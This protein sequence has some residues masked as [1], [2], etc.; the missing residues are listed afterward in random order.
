[1]GDGSLSAA[2][3]SI[4]VDQMLKPVSSNITATIWRIRGTL[5]V[6]RLLVAIRQT[7]EETPAL[8]VRFETDNVGTPRA[9]PM[10]PSSFSPQFHDVSGTGV[11][12][13]DQRAREKLLGLCSTPFALDEDRLFRV[14]VVRVADD[15]HVLGLVIHHVLTDAYGVFDVLSQRIADAYHGHHRV[16]P[17]G[18]DASPVAPGLREETYRRSPFFAEDADFWR[19]YLDEAAPAARMPEHGVGTPASPDGWWDTLGSPLG[20]S[21]STVVIPRADIADTV[22]ASGAT[23][24]VGFPD[25]LMASIVGFISRVG[26]AHSFTFS[27]TVNFRQGA[28]RN[29]PGLYSNSVP[30]SVSLSQTRSTA[31]LARS[32]KADRLEVLQHAEYNVAMMKRVVGRTGETRSPFGP[33]VNVMPFLKELDLGTAVGTLAGGLFGVPDEV[34]ISVFTDGSPSSDLFARV[35]APAALYSAAEVRTLGGLLA[36]YLTDALRSPDTAIENVDLMP[37]SEGSLGLPFAGDET[38]IDIDALLADRA[39]ASPE[40]VAVTDRESSLSH[41][42]LIEQARSVRRLLTRAGVTSGDIVALGLPPCLALIPVQVGLAMSGAATAPL[43]PGASLDSLSDADAARAPGWMVSLAGLDEIVVTP[44]ADGVPVWNSSVTSADVPDPA[45]APIIARDANAPGYVASGVSLT[46]AGLQALV[47]QTAEVAGIGPGDTVAVR[48]SGW[49]CLCAVLAGASI[50]I[51]PPPSQRAVLTVAFLGTGELTDWLSE[52]GAPDGMRAIIHG[53]EPLPSPTRRAWASA[54]G[55]RLYASLAPSSQLPPFAITSLD[56]IGAN[57]VL[58]GSVG[59][60]DS[61]L[62]P[63]GHG[64]VGRLHAIVP[65]T[66]ASSRDGVALGIHGA[67]SAFALPLLAGLEHGRLRVWG[68]ARRF[69]A[70]PAGTLFLAPVERALEAIDGVAEAASRVVPVESTPSQPRLT[71]YVV[72]AGGGLLGGAEGSMSFAAGLDM[73]AVRTHAGALVAGL[74]TIGDVIV[75]DAILRTPDG[76]PRLDELPATTQG[77]SGLGASTEQEERVADLFRQ[78]LGRSGVGSGDDFFQLGGDSITA[79][80]LA[81]LARR[82]GLTL[83]VRDVFEYRTVGLLAQ[84]V[85]R[86]EAGPRALGS[87]GAS[88]HLYPLPPVAHV[89]DRGEPFDRFAQWMALTSPSGLDRAQLTT[90]LQRLLDRHDALRSRRIDTGM[91]VSRSGSLLAERLLE[92]VTVDVDPTTLSFSEVGTFA[93]TAISHIDARLAD[94]VR[95]VWIEGSSGSTGLLVIVFHHLVIDGVSWQI[96]LDD[97]AAS[98][99]S[100]GDDSETGPEP[101]NLPVTSA[102]WTHYV[103]DAARAESVQGHTAWAAILQGLHVD[104]AVL[105]PERDVVSTSGSVSLELDP[106]LSG[107]LGSW[108]ARQLG[109]GVE[110]LLLAAY[111]MALPESSDGPVVIRMEGH[112]RDGT[113]PDGRDAAQ[114][115]GWF[116]SVYPLRIDVSDVSSTA[117]DPRLAAARAIM[118]TREGRERLTSEPSSYALRAYAPQVLGGVDAVPRADRLGFN[119]LGRFGGTTAG[120]PWSPAAQTPVIIGAPDPQM[121]LASVLN[122]DA[123]SIP[124]NGVETIVATFT[125]A[126]RHLH[127]SAAEDIANRWSQMLALFRDLAADAPQTV[128]PAMAQHIST[129]EWSSLTRRYGQ[130]DDIWP[131]AP[132]QHGL[133]YHW[134]RSDDSADSY[135][136]QFVFALEGEIDSGRLAAAVERVVRRLPNLRVVFVDSEGGEP[137]QVVLAPGEASVPCSVV[138]LRTDP[139]SAT[140]TLGELL[141]EDRRSR[142]DLET[143]PPLRFTTYLLGEQKAHLSLSAHHI[144]LDG[145][146]LPLLLTEILRAYAQG[147]DYDTVPDTTFESALRHGLSVSKGPSIAAWEAELAGLDAPLLVPP[148]RLSTADGRGLEEPGEVNVTVPR[149]TAVRVA[150][151]ASRLGVTTSALVQAAWALTLSLSTGSDDIVF[152]STVAVRPSDVDGSDE[153][154]GMLTN[155]IPVRVTIGLGLTLADLALRVRETSLRMMDHWHLGLG[156]ILAATYGRQLFDSIVVFE[157]FPIDQSALRDASRTSELHVTGITPFS[158]THYPYTLLAAADPVFSATIQYRGGPARLPEAQR[159]AGYLATVIDAFVNDPTTRVAEIEHVTSSERERMLRFLNDTDADRPQTTVAAMFAARA[160]IAADEVAVIH[161]DRSWTYADLDREANRIC[162]W[163]LERSVGRGDKI[164][165]AVPRSMTCLAAILGIWH[166][167][168]VYVPLDPSLPESRFATIVEDSAP[169]VI[170]TASVASDRPWRRL[171][172]E[173]SQVLAGAHDGAYSFFTSGS[174]GRPQGVLVSHG[175]LANFFSAMQEIVPAGAG[176]RWLSV[177]TISFD[178]SLLELFQ[179]LVRGAAV[180]IADDDDRTDSDKVWDLVRTAGVT[181]VQ[182][183]PSLWRSLC[184]EAMTEVNGLRALVGGEAL[185]AELAERL[186]RRASTVLNLYG[187]TETTIWSTCAVLPGSRPPSIGRPIRNTQV[188]VLDRAL[189]PLPVGRVGEVW[190]AGAGLA[191]GYLNSPGRT[192]SRFVANPF[193]GRSGARMYRTGDLGRWTVDGQIELLGR[194]DTQ[195]K[196]RGFRI[197]LAEVERLLVRHPDIEQALASLDT[198][199]GGLP[200][201][202]AHLVLEDPQ[203]DEPRDFSAFLRREVPEYMHPAVTVVVDSYPLNANGKIDRKGLPEPQEVLDSYVEPSTGLQATLCRLFADAL[204]LERVGVRDEFVALGGHSL[205]ATRLVSRIRTELGVEVP[206]RTL[207]AEQT[208]EQLSARWHELGVARRSAITRSTRS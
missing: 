204:G 56:D 42:E 5:D 157:S 127:R 190:I 39:A 200:R 135:Q 170:I 126:S 138:D 147:D 33:I 113:L 34:M 171:P 1:M 50:A 71:L 109:C 184:T 79:L 177:T 48:T 10:A 101:A 141:E 70:S 145:W 161:G 31:D 86:T 69:A 60:L 158:P 129:R 47:R 197:E 4:L 188:Y 106:S 102:E 29:A 137:L 62:T 49:E 195:V 128:T 26:D 122:L 44:I 167:G 151:T 168:A 160:R 51:M 207:F 152:G 75:V 18:P 91:S 178:I 112:G 13:A 94:L 187:P 146:S 78:V 144:L 67:T 208:I 107:A 6:D 96:V 111:V 172:A 9:V 153:C 99:E 196:L 37:T 124:V 22:A 43:A 24:D 118:R 97:L 84:C 19:G 198:S 76:V 116:T 110:D 150:A 165:V 148:D 30:L 61:R 73:A 154:I 93:A 66:W 89:F 201:L 32:L 120:A 57:D 169:L 88:P 117:A 191:V 87:H 202:I 189:R 17:I 115:V 25:L 68:D 175:A 54:N 156:D 142:F 8:H 192:A 173:R 100:V 199:P 176:Q 205:I 90:L 35:D 12:T 179:P 104:D 40:G 27:F 95:F 83:A 193:S 131:L 174:T 15:D 2:Q 11:G 52:S 119:Y 98:Y 108:V 36:R 28:Y 140:A 16:T 55:G 194:N 123:A 63:V 143:A 203:L 38:L 59:V 64:L 21:S 45:V 180:V 80:R 181:T 206:I 125:F 105:D 92:V 58:A 3:E 23:R 186:V 103:H 121:P 162:N 41:V 166:A 20:V 159:L 82:T 149:S 72:P 77:D 182:A 85:T 7:F 46:H 164:A 163:L 114:T 14:A 183:T 185:E 139:M 65:T 74:A 134:L 53:S 132:L 130:V 136:M 81:S 155:T 133:Y